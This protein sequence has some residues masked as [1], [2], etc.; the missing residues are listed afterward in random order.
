M[1]VSNNT[2]ITVIPKSNH[3]DA[4]GDYRPIAYCNTM[5]KIISKML[6]NRVKL[7][8]SDIISEKNQSAFVARRTIMENILIC[9]DLVRLYNR[10]TATKSCLIKVDLKKAYDSIEWDFVEEMLHALNFPMRFIR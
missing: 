8:S 2:V 5:Y 4:V 1:R 9:Q 10:K 6:C 3:A 7:V